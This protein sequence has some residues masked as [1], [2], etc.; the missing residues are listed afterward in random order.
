[1]SAHVLATAAAQREVRGHATETR[2]RG[3]KKESARGHRK[4][5]GVCQGRSEQREPG[6]RRRGRQRERGREGG[7]GTRGDETV[8]G[9]EGL[10]VGHSLGRE[11]GEAVSDDAVDHLAVARLL[12]L[13]QRTAA[14]RHCEARG[15]RMSRATTCADRTLHHG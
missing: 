9:H 6:W 14:V 15:L 1:M 11:D 3:D 2:T 7:E 4:E 8:L 10:E 12:D 5:G 13:R